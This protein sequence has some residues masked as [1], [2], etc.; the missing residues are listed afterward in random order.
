MVEYFTLHIVIFKVKKVKLEEITE[1]DP[2]LV[3][4]ATEL[5]EEDYSDVKPDVETHPKIEDELI[6]IKEECIEANF[7]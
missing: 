7:Q 6:S 5:L 2:L 1:E 4:N 3:S